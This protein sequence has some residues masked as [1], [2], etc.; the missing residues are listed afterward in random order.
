[1]PHGFNCIFL[2]KYSKIGDNCTIY[3]NVTI[4]SVND[5]APIIKNNVLIGTGAILLGEVTIGANSKIGA[6][7]IVVKDVPPNSTVIPNSS[8]IR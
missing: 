7:S 1:L 2:S 6:G 8:S 5:K 3:H 4:G